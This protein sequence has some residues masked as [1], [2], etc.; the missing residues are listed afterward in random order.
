MIELKNLSF[1]YQGA[2]APILN[3]LSLTIP[4]HTLTLVTGTS[5]SGKSTFLKCIN[6]LVPHFTGGEIS[7][8]ISVSGQNPI[9]VGPEVMSR[10]VGYIFQEPETQFVYDNLEDE[11]AFAMENA[12]LPRAEMVKRLDEICE[13]LSLQP[14]RQQALQT[15]SGGEMQ[16]VAIGSVLVNQPQVLILDE[17]TSQLDPKT[18]D[19][20]LQH[21]VELKETLGITILIAEHRLERLLPY[22]DLVLHLTPNQQPVFGLPREVLTRMALVP[23][24][25]EIGRHLNLHPLPI[26]EEQFPI[27][28]SKE[29]SKTLV[30]EIHKPASAAV[31]SA[32]R[33][34]VILGASEIIRDVSMDLFPGEILILIGPNGS[35]KTTLLRALLGLIPSSG[36]RYLQGRDITH[37]PTND[38]IHAVGYLPQNPNDL[39]FADSTLDELRITLDNH[40]KSLDDAALCHFLAQFDLDSYALAYPRD[41]SVGQRQ[42]SALAAISVHNPPILFLDEP[43]RGLAYENKNKLAELLSKWRDRGTAIFMVTHDVEFA[44]K[45]ADRVILMEA[46]QF[47]F[48]GDPHLAFTQFPDYRTQTAR[49]FPSQRWIRPDEVPERK[50]LVIKSAV[51]K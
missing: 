12:H 31:L 39:L 20:L 38:I 41:L 14:L 40:G 43:T 3:N 35:G 44:A 51:V 8:S 25:V 11:I 36:G 17:P 49:L 30:P 34:S 22:T 28:T 18:A 13:I 24:L 32:E 45:L 42:R 37:Q 10:S 50:N 19:Q 48:T 6:G 9:Q 2:S 46:G 7:G 33:L 27:L 29:P 16:R 15:L 26:S 4:V 23:P 5:G 1:S 47:R 21:I